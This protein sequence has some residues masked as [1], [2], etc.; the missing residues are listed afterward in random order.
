MG[1]GRWKVVEARQARQA[2]AEKQRG[3][4]F[5]SLCVQYVRC[6]IVDS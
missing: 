3:S 2:L 4:L 6:L 1:D 5:S